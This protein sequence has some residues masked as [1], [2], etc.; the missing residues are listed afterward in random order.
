MERQLL[1]SFIVIL[2]VGSSFLPITVG[3]SSDKQEESSEISLI[4]IKVAG[5]SGLNDWYFSDIIFNITNESDE[6]SVVYYKIKQEWMLYNKPFTVSEDGIYNLEWYS[7][8]HEGNQSEVDGP[9]SFRIDQ[10]PPN[11][12]LSYELVGGNKWDGW[13]FLF[14]VTATDDMSGMDKVEFFIN[15]VLKETIYGIGPIYQLSWR[16]DGKT[17]TTLKAIGYDKAGNSK[18]D[19]ITDS[20]E[21]TILKITGNNN[22]E[23][24]QTDLQS[25]H[26]SDED[27]SGKIVQ[28]SSTAEINDPSYVIV[29]FDRKLGNN[30]WCVNN[31]TF[32][33]ILDSNEIIE[34]YYK[35]DDGDW[36][37]FSE[38]IDISEEGVHSFSWYVVD[39]EG[40]K[41]T[42]D[43]I[44]FKIDM[45]PPDI[46]LRKERLSIDEIKFI[47]DVDD[48]MSGI[49]K[50]NF[51]VDDSLEFTDYDYPYEWNWIGWRNEKVEAK[52]FDN[53]GNRASD[54]TGTL[55]NYNLNSQNINPKI[56]S[57]MFFFPMLEQLLS[58]LR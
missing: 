46:N 21:N 31:G 6:I 56:S 30:D 33:F 5:E 7:V 26:I 44:D 58:L 51:I 42:P 8:N 36:T 37:I 25:I 3:L 23:S 53:A 18:E 47:A 49:A 1:I 11:V 55:F 41:S 50:V 43:S 14:I 52:V 20:F 19:K 13:D 28:D 35:I 15:D 39:S 40:N 4:T 22:F 57:S 12:Y 38:P 2:V 16:W 17:R 9:F 24:I 54:S 27:I 10:T 48:E 32:S 45:S 29:I 34:V